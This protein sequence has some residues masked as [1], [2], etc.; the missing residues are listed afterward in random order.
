[1]LIV[2]PSSAVV[3]YS[4]SFPYSLFHE[5]AFSSPHWHVLSSPQAA[6]RTRALSCG[7]SCKNAIRTQEARSTDLAG[8]GRL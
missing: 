8:G 2:S 5:A 6:S 4:L 1:M 3:L 7:P